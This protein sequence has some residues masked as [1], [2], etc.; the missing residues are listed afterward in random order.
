M[1]IEHYLPLLARRP[2]AFPYAKPV[3]QWEMPEVYRLFYERL[4]RNY[5]GDGVR[6]FIQVLLMGRQVGR[7]ILERAMSRA[8]AE[9]R[10]DSERIRQLINIADAGGVPQSMPRDYL[11]RSRVVLP[12]LGQFDR[13]RAAVAA[14]GGE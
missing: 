3:R 4:C 9:N 1:E 8:L 14:E 12:E 11:E 7:E 2:G 10:A 13:L 5:N 6:E